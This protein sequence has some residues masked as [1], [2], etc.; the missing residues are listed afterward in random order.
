MASTSAETADSL[1]A[2]LD[3]IQERVD[4]DGAEMA[5]GKLSLGEI[6]DLVGRRAYGPLLLIIGVLS[7]SPLALLPGST[8]AFAA[9]TLLVAVQMALHLKH[10]WLPPA[11]L[12]V[13]FPEKEIYGALRSVR[14]WTRAVDTM[15]KPRLEFL[16]HEPWLLL[17][18]L[19]AIVAALVTFPLSFIPFAPFIPG[20]TIILIGLGVTARDGLLLS[21]ALSLLAIAGVWLATRLA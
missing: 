3:R 21:L 11:A 7:V 14:P 6:L 17:V 2:M 20:A 19:L 9:L 5:D 8:W 13:S 15:V 4:A 12:R 1:T 10:P 18:A 16:A